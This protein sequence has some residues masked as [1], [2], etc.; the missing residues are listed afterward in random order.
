MDPQ[1]ADLVAT[2]M[3]AVQHADPLNP[4]EH[5]KKKKPKKTLISGFFKR[6]ADEEVRE[7]REATEGAAE[8][9]KAAREL[10]KQEILVKFN[11]LVAKW[12]LPRKGTFSRGP[13]AGRTMLAAVWIEGLYAT[14]DLVAN[15]NMAEP[16]LIVLPP[17]DPKK[18][19]DI[20]SWKPW[21]VPTTGLTP[22]KYL[23]KWSRI[24]SRWR[25]KL[26]RLLPNVTSSWLL[27]VPMLKVPM[28]K[29]P[30]LKQKRSTITLPGNGRSSLVFS[31]LC[32]TDL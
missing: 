18:A 8:L 32:Q 5:S 10:K 2:D 11:V 7:E 19:A 14:A 4:W 16:S 28:R 27:K 24:T 31:G 12:N 6:E 15:G 30:M 22:Q 23:R 26:L 25:T 17:L 20:P 3:F 1:D 13:G 21:N 9:K 29:V